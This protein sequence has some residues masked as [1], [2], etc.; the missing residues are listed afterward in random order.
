MRSSSTW[1]SKHKRPEHPNEALDTEPL[2]EIHD[3]GLLERTLDLRFV[4]SIDRHENYAQRRTRPPELPHEIASVAIGQPEL[5][6]QDECSRS[7][8]GIGIRAVND[9]ALLVTI[10]SQ[11]HV[12]C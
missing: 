9:E 12:R 11:G 3:A 8:V 2:F 4:G 6:H 10:L 5:R 7:V 1:A